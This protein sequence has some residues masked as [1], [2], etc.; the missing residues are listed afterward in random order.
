MSCHV[1]VIAIVRYISSGYH[2]CESFQINYTQVFVGVP[3][4]SLIKT[5]HF[6]VTLMIFNPKVKFTARLFAG[7]C[8]LYR[9]VQG[10][11]VSALRRH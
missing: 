6:L 5:R 1:I 3:K 8:L 2:N 4:V 9:S 10:R 11:L 7:Y